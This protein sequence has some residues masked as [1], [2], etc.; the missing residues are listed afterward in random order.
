M[1]KKK[2]TWSELKDEKCPN[3]KQT[4]TTDM[5]SGDTVGCPNCG[6]VIKKEAKDLLVDRDKDE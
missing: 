3:C 5:F 4:L 6:F 2:K 1:S